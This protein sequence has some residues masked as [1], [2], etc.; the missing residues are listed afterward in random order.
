VAQSVEL[1]FDPVTE[2]ALRQQWDRL[3][4]AGLPSSRRSQPDPHNRPHLTLYAAETIS[5]EADERL[6]QLFEGLHLTLRIGSLMIFGPR[7]GQVILVRSVVPSAEL[8]ALQARTTQLCGADA[9]GQFG[10]GGWTPHVTLARRMALD[11]LR[12]A[13]DLVGDSAAELP[14]VVR[15]CRRWD[16][17]RRTVRWLT[18]PG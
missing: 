14:S 12:M 15:R 13:I 16:G 18:E 3:A 1:I 10:A 9:A 11:Q 5:A 2:N 4:D 17:Q 7:H 8:L 6:P